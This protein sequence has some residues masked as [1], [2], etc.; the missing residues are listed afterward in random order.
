MNNKKKSLKPQV[1]A[2]VERPIPCTGIVNQQ[3][4]GGLEIYGGAEG[5]FV[6]PLIIF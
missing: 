2:P 5:S 1:S 4:S 6:P 3:P